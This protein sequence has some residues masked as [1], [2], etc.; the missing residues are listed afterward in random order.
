MA[1]LI[2]SNFLRIPLVY[3]IQTTLLF[4]QVL[5]LFSK[6]GVKLLNCWSCFRRHFLGF[7]FLDCHRKIL[8]PPQCRPEVMLIEDFLQEKDHFLRI[9]FLGVKLRS[10]LK[11]L[12]DISKIPRIMF[13]QVVHDL[14]TSFFLNY[15][16]LI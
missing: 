8:L 1:S 15:S 13:P 3:P 9:S 12:L 4:V 5:N 11:K 14:Q 16:G 6:A 2:S 10:L 7:Y